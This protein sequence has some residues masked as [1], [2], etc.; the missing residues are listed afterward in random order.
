MR[1]RGGPMITTTPMFA[2]PEVLAG[3][4]PGVRSDVYALGVLLYRLLSAVWPVEGDSGDAADRSAR[5]WRPRAAR[6]ATIGRASAPRPHRRTRPGARSGS[7]ASRPPP[8]LRDALGRML[9]QRPRVHPARSRADHVGARRGGGPHASALRLPSSGMLTM[10][11]R[12]RSA[13]A[14]VGDV[15]ASVKWTS[16]PDTI[17]SGLGWFVSGRRLSTADG[18]ADVLVSDAAWSRDD[19]PQAGSGRWCSPGGATGSAERRPGPISGAAFERPDWRQCVV[20]AR[21]RERRDR[22]EDAL[23]RAP[24]QPDGQA[25]GDRR[26]CSLFPG[27]AARPPRGAGLRAR[28]RHAGQRVPAIASR[29]PATRQPRQVRRRTGVRAQWNGEHLQAGARVAHIP[30]EARTG[31]ARGRRGRWSAL[32]SA[33]RSGAGMIR[34]RR[35]GH[36]ARRLRRRDGG[37]GV[38][39]GPPRRGGRGRPVASGARTACAVYPGSRIEG[40][41]ERRWRWRDALGGRHRRRQRR[42]FRGCGDRRAGHGDRGADTAARSACCLGRRDGLERRPACGASKGTAAPAS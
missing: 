17:L 11:T 22:I 20:S 10:R 7:H 34:H 21:R 6:D 41:P 18:R 38:L 39:A 8:E 15:D 37:L 32:P 3:G 12:S 30:P 36:Q 4:T 35:Q 42:R 14:H 19:V 40:R 27:L 1:A 16:P 5:A 2:A 24:R 23:V 13:G 9:G 29:R 25:G 31:S 28:Q 33:A 26:G